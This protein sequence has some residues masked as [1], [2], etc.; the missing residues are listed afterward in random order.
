MYSS[1]I[2]AQ[3]QAEVCPYLGSAGI[4]CKRRTCRCP[5]CRELWGDAEMQKNSYANYTCRFTLFKH[6]SQS[7][8]VALMRW[9]LKRVKNWAYKNDEMFHA[10]L[11]PEQTPTG[12]F[13]YHGALRCSKAV[14]ARLRSAWTDISGKGHGS[15]SIVVPYSEG[16]LA[17]CVKTGRQR[18]YV[19]VRPV[20]R[21]GRL[22]L[23]CAVGKWVRDGG[24][25]VY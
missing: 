21:K 3:F 19:P 16:A 5:E 14:V 7:D 10:R 22:V 20:K 24:D 13:H 25:Y 2:D 23:T 11:Y 12:P 17:Y 18:D 4:P 9:V 1:D 8:N 6:W 15:Y